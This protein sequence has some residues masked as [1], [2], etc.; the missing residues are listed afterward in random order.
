MLNIIESRTVTS[1]S[2]ALLPKPSS[3]T[4]L[5]KTSPIVHTMS[6]NTN[7]VLLLNIVR[8]SSVRSVMFLAMLPMCP[9]DKSEN[10]TSIAAI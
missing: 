7:V 4:D 3:A 6:I 9:S 5:H 10:S 2:A 8:M 1:L